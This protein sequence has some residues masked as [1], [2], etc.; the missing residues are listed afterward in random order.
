M[1]VPGRNSPP[2][3]YLNL[4]GRRLKEIR[5]EKGISATAMLARL[6]IQGWS[7]HNSTL[8]DLEAGRRIISDVELMVMLKV[9]RADLTDLLP[10]K[11]R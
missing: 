6:E 4:F 1:G 3:K 9:L 10:P 5:L 2:S 11:R 7:I 8:S